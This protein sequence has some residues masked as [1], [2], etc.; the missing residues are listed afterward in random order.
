MSWIKDLDG[1]LVNL[2]HCKS[3]DVSELEAQT[4]HETHC[5]VAQW[6]DETEGRIL[7]TGS[8]EQMRSKQALIASKLPMVKLI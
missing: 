6:V 1:H 3:I 7:D 4:Q 2:D 8:E 5:I